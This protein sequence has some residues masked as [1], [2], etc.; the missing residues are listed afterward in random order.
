MRCTCDSRRGCEA[1]GPQPRE[2]EV[3]CCKCGYWTWNL[4]AICDN[5]YDAWLNKDP[6]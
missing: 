3:M 2:R 1:H 4:A 6:F 5:C